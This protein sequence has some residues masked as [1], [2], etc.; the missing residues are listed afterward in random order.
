MELLALMESHSSHPLSATLVNAAQSEGV[1]IPKEVIVEDHTTIPGEGLTA[2]IDQKLVYL[3]NAR[4]FQRIGYYQNL[5]EVYKQS[6]MEWSKSGCTVGYL[7]VQDVGIIAMFCV[8]DNLREEAVG[9]VASLQTMGML[10]IMITGDGEGTAIAVADEVGIDMNHVHSQCL[11]EDKMHH[12]GRLQGCRSRREITSCYNQDP[13]VCMVG[14]GVNDSPAL[15]RAD[16]V[17]SLHNLY[18][19]E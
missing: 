3:G 13:L 17:R 11:P 5:A 16:V 10:V 2:T 18:S 4:L 15:K 12:I 7:G 9:V 19:L 8:S 14:D 6:S 1:T